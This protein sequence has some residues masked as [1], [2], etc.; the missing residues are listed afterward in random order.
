MNTKIK[1][2][3]SNTLLFTIANMGSKI[4]VFLMV[5]LYTAVLTTNEYGIADMV[6]TTATML[7]PILTAMVAEA[8]LRFCFLKEYSCD[9]VLSIGIRITICGILLCA[10]LSL[11]FLI[12]PFFKEIGLYVLFI[13]V[14]FASNS[15]MNLFHKYCRGT[16]KVK[17]SASAGLLSTFVLILLNL[18]FLLVLKIG[19][20]GYLMA[21]ALGDFSAIIYMAIK[22]KAVETY[23]T[24]KNIELRKEM[25]KYSIPL[26]PNS[27]SWWAISS[28][29]RYIMLAWLGVSA[30]GIYSATLR[31][32]SILTVL[33]DIFAQAWLLSAL[34]DYGSDESKRFIRSMHNKYFA[35]LILLTACIILLAYPLAKI[36]LS[37]DFSQYWW[38]TP[39]LFISVFYGALVGFLGSIF[40]SERKNTM[41]FV[42]TMIGA[43]VSILITVLFLNQYGVSVVAISTMVGYYVIWL[44]RRIAVNKYIN[45]GYGTINSSLQGAV[46]LAEAI[47]VGREMYL[48][49]VLCVIS[50][51]VINIKEI[52]LIF[53]FGMLEICNIVNR[54]NNKL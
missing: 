30:V 41:Q 7:I 20:L 18:F 33:C 15:M 24:T 54:K 16:D 6:Q 29:N 46:L 37:G 44:I 39:Y 22:G 9:E 42:S 4:M 14:L 2:L 49:A 19:V 5:P 27:L 28:V 17:V 40:S 43:I 1:E 48:W 12:I 47:L 32:P 3:L 11:C 50:L 51:V 35:L 8:V 36:L 25:F 53:K 38:V 23:T 21:Y 52:I 31:I 34:K 13:P 26:V 45:V 10:L